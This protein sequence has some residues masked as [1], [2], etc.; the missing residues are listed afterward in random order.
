[1]VE[2]VFSQEIDYEALEEQQRQSRLRNL[3][4]MILQF[5]SD[6]IEQAKDITNYLTT[7]DWQQALLE[8][9]RREEEAIEAEMNTRR[10]AAII[11][12]EA[13][14]KAMEQGGGY[15]D[16]CDKLV[17][18]L[19]GW[20][21]LLRAGEFPLKVYRQYCY[22]CLSRHESGGYGNREFVFCCSVCRRL[23][24]MKSAFFIN[25]RLCCLHC[26]EQAAEGQFI[27][28]KECDKKTASYTAKGIC[29]DCEIKSPYSGQVTLHLARA[30]QAGTP[31]TLTLR[32]WVTAV[33]YFGNK[34]AY[35]RLRPFEVLEHFLPI[36]LGGGTT[37][38]NC[39]PACQSCNSKK[40]DAHPNRFVRL[41]SAEIIEHIQQYLASDKR[42]INPIA[43]N[44]RALVVWK[45]EAA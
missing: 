19:Y 28:C 29:Y 31:A 18:R 12:I 6:D 5:V 40:G 37:A 33:E 7:V 10:L 11:Q 34:C 45:G 23:A 26:I 30:R 3:K 24:W 1:M 17:N 36:S 2:T 38:E 32:E 27:Q 22:R 13:I 39:V 43:V 16:E 25:D 20:P 4:N 8:R 9:R 21:Y 15:C 41:F 44:N 35:C 42:G 14:A